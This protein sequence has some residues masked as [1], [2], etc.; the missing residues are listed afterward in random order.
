MQ[1]GVS[2]QIRAHGARRTNFLLIRLGRLPGKP[3]IYTGACCL[4]HQT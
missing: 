1:K 3:D 4:Q 2:K